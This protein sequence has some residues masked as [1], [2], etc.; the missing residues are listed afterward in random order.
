MKELDNDKDS[1][2]CNKN[3]IVI[4]N[5]NTLLAI[6]LCIIL[7]SISIYLF[8]TT[9]NVGANALVDSFDSSYLTE[10]EN[11]KE[12]IKAAFFNSAERKYHA[13]NRITIFIGDITEEQKLEVLEVSDVEF[14]V[15][16][17]KDNSS[18]I[19][20]WLE[21]PGKATFVI[22]LQA[23]E[24]IVDNDRAYVKV[25]VPYPE[26]SNVTIDYANVN[27]LLFKDDIF[28]GSYKEGED[29]AK[30]QLEQADLLI[31]K[32]FISNQNFYMNAQKSAT[33]TI[34]NRVKQ[35]NPEVQ[36]INVEVEFF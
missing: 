30:Q 29:L 19:C 31:K 8:V 7:A 15:E 10:R 21:V 6:C 35:W 20:S 24:F 17:R 1:I 11:T 5:R 25:R 18:N 33:T 3:E 14:I 4:N 2:S 28:N 16:D 22:D 34:V 23:A 13:S 9:M 12:V 36:D 27:K 26:L 32:E